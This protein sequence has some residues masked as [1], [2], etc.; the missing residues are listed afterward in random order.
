MALTLTI[1]GVDRRLWYESKS[2]KLH[3]EGHEERLAIALVDDEIQAATWRPKNGGE[4]HITQDGELLFGG[5]IDSVIEEALAPPNLAGLRWKVNARDWTYTT[6][7]TLVGALTVA[8][9]TPVLTAAENVRA[10]YLADRWNVQPNG[11]T[12]GGT[13]LDELTF[14]HVTVRAVLDK[15]TEQTGYFWRIN[16][17]CLFAMHPPGS[18]IGPTF[19]AATARII[20]T[21]EWRKQSLNRYTRLWLAVTIADA[22]KLETKTG[23]GV[24]RVFPLDWDVAEA[25]GQVIETR[26]GTGTPYP[27]PGDRWTYDAREQALVQNA[28]APVLGAGDLLDYSVH[29]APARLGPRRRYRGARGR[30][31]DHR[32]DCLGVG[33]HGD[34]RGGG[35]GGAPTRAPAARAG[36]GRPRDRRRERLPRHGVRDYR[37]RAPRDRQLSHQDRRHG[38]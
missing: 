36:G 37:R 25:P 8:A 12:A 16:G 29:A 30:R 24:R 11:P 2:L 15:F 1:D 7:V 21:F 38:R 6:D 31:E 32:D 26:G 35:G 17:D 4:V 27:V 14:D 28:S 33:D 5:V 9:G 34:G 19:D 10:T 3:K 20:N 22:L 13:L 18:I 23:D